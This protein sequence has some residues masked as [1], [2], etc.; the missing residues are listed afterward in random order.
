MISSN[1]PA[2]VTI[3][4]KAFLP[5]PLS[6]WA[7]SLPQLWSLC[8]LV[9]LGF[10]VCRRPSPCSC[11]RGILGP[12]SPPAQ[13]TMDWKCS[14]KGFPGGSVVKNLPAKAG[15]GDST[16]DLGR[17]RTPWSNNYWTCDLEPRSRNR[18]VHVLRLLKPECPRACAPHREKPPPWGAHTT[19]E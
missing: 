6:C 16:P 3:I 1:S 19:G 9:S 7:T 17:S 13:S 12:F 8:F 18:W 14:W 4:S 10:H 5:C 15:G 2:E 11:P